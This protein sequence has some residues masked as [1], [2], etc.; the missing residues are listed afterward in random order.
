MCQLANS[1]NFGC[2][3]APRLVTLETFIV[4][5]QACLLGQRLLPL[6]FE[7][8]AHQSVLRFYGIE[9]PAGS[10]R[11]VACSFEPMAPLSVQR[12]ALAFQLAGRQQAYL[13]RSRLERLHHKPAYQSIKRRRLER[14]ADRSSVV[15]G[16]VDTYVARSG[17]VLVVLGGHS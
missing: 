16:Q 1:C 9:L 2:G 10:L 13:Q 5:C 6:A 4:P 15:A 8:T 12:R 7:S 14:L 11:L 3:Q 17:A